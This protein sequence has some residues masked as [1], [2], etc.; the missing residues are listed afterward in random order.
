MVAATVFPDTGKP[1]KSV[2]CEST[3]GKYK[4]EEGHLIDGELKDT[5]GAPKVL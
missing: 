2:V 4:D 3:T 1:T 5:C